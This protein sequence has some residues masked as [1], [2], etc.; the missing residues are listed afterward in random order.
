[1]LKDKIDQFKAQMAGKV[2]ADAKQIMAESTAG[3]AAT[4]DSRDIPKKGDVLKPFEL[5]DSQGNMHSLSG[6]TA[7]KPLII[8][9]FRGDW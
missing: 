1:M 7:D 5:P 9:L 3:V 6:L 4:L 8:T 2:P